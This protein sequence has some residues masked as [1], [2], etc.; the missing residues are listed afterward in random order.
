MLFEAAA[1]M[2]GDP[3]LKVTLKPLGRLSAS[4]SQLNAFFSPGYP[5][6]YAALKSVINNTFLA[7]AG[8]TEPAPRL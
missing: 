7:S 1:G 2:A 8:V 6:N 4:R 3:V 5:L